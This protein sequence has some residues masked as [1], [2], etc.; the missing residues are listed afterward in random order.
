M[1]AFSFLTRNTRHGVLWNLTDHQLQ[2]A[3]LGRLDEKPLIVDHFAELALNDEEAF[4]RWAGEAM[5]DR[6]PGYMHAYCGF[7]PPERVLLREV[8]NTRRMPETNYL[9]NLLAEAAKLPTV[10]DWQVCALHP[11]EG[12]KFSL[13]SPSRPGLLVGLPQSVVRDTQNRLRKLTVRPRSL[14]LGTLS[15]LG[16]LTRYVR[17]LN[18]PH[19]VV[20]CEIGNTTTRIYFLAKDGVHTPAALP[21]GLLSIEESA[22][23]ELSA[24]DIAA[25]RLQLESPTDELKS[26][27][28]RLVRAITRHLKPA[29]DYFEMQ[30]GQPIGA[31]FCAHLPPKLGWLEETLCAAVDLEFLIPDYKVWLPR[32]GVEVSADSP[33]PGRGWFQ[34]LCLIGQLTPPLANE[35]KT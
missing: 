5:A 4:E 34:A 32:I 25:A 18:Y 28:R 12:E 33:P 31:L 6:G 23:K 8:V 27:G 35:P 9:E 22:M 30:T 11:V 14:E 17:E 20:V 21:H 13:N 16:G 2:V 7:H 15:L 26:H 19:A 29:V 10:K 3:R 24:P 1:A